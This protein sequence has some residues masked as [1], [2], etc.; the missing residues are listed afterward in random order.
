[1]SIKV[2][3]ESLSRNEVI[4]QVILHLLVV[5]FYS[6]DRHQ[7]KIDFYQ[8]VFFL[9]SAVAA[10]LIN[11]ILLPKF[12][13]RKRYLLFGGSFLLII[14]GVLLIEECVLEQI[15]FPDT[16][17]QS[18]PGVIFSLLGV[19]PVIGILSGFK[20]GWD[21]MGKQ[22]EVDQLKATIRESEMLFLRSQINPHFLF[23][24]LNN[25][26]A[27][28][29][30]KSPKTPSIILELSSVLRYMLYE[31]KEKYVP[32]DKEI[33]HLQNFTRLNE[34]Q[35]EERGKVIFKS[36]VVQPGF[37]IAP[38]ILLVFIEN[39]FK[40][41]QASQS[42]DIY[43]NIDIQLSDQGELR[44]ICKNNFKP[45]TNTDNL[46]HGIGLE[47]VKKRLQLIYPDAHHLKIIETRNQFEVLLSLHLNKI[48]T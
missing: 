30:E 21:A 11:Y 13:Y 26:Y 19:L 47:N 1:M 48:Q 29:I 27:Y 34:M 41:S 43:I 44:F 8:I 4:F 2:R 17:G 39:A 32:L 14:T 45:V 25:L 6:Y 12:L 33:E 46:G 7:H 16:R 23:N 20:L 28:A 36:P 18:F 40:H 22:Q 42:E 35:I 31:C 3:G 24:N 9:N 10:F 37:E 5:T 38:L 15:F